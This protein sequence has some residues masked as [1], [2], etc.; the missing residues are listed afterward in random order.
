MIVCNY[1]TMKYNIDGVVKFYY[2]ILILCVHL[3]QI[4]SAHSDRRRSNHVVLVPAIT[5]RLKYKI[6]KDSSIFFNIIDNDFKTILG[7]FLNNFFS[8]T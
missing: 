5:F 8:I 6:L 2:F 1:S 4:L 3:H 7:I